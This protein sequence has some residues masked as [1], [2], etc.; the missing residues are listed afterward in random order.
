[1]CFF[2]FGMRGCASR[3]ERRGRVRERKRGRDVSDVWKITREFAKRVITIFQ[4]L[5][6]ENNTT[7]TGIYGF[8]L[9]GSAVCM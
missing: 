8:V 2:V 6:T 7:A 1:M 9:L 3:C 4:S 5:I